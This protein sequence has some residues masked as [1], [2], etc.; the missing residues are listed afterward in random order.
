M[1]D[2]AREAGRSGRGH[3]RQGIQSSG[4]SIALD[5]HGVQPLKGGS[6]PR[7]ASGVAALPRQYEPVDQCH[8]LRGKVEN[9]ARDH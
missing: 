7:V 2:H 4:P 9:G 8:S 3:D 1:R 6:A 5:F